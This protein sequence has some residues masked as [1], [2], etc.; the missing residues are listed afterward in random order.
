[1][2]RC[3][4]RT[5]SPS[6]ATASSIR[7][8]STVRRGPF[9]RPM[10]RSA[11]R[12]HHARSAEDRGRGS[13]ARGCQ[14]RQRLLGRQCDAHRQPVADAPLRGRHRRG[15]IKVS[16][17]ITGRDVVMT[18]DAR[19]V[20]SFID[21]N[22]GTLVALA[23]QTV[24]GAMFG[25]NGSYVGSTIASKIEIASTAVIEATRNVSLSASGRQEARCRPSRS[26]AISP[27]ARRCRSA[28]SPGR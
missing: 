4:P 21:P 18:A 8:T 16:G 5:A 12:Q 27:G 17:T 7:A 1:M 3:W 9:P 19:A 20:S 23:A 25:L 14:R 26:R 28:R 2:C 24:G 22:A 6:G 11:T 13:V 10:H 15:R